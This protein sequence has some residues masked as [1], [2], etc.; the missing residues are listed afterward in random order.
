MPM[1]LNLCAVYDIFGGLYSCVQSFGTVVP[2][3]GDTTL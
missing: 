2:V 3:V 1:T